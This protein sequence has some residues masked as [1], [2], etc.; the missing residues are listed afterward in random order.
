MNSF[1]VSTIFKHE[2]Q[3]IPEKPV[4]G[5][6]LFA[7]IYLLFI[8]LWISCYLTLIRTLSAFSMRQAIT[9]IFETAAMNTEYKQYTDITTKQYMNDF[10]N[11]VVI[12]RIYDE[13]TKQYMPLNSNYHYINYYN[14]FMGLRI[15]QNRVDLSANSNKNSNDAKSRIRK[16][17]YSGDTTVRYGDLD[18]TEFGTD[19]IQYWKSCGYANAGGFVHFFNSSITLTQ[20]QNKFNTMIIVKA[21]V[22]TSP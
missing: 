18:K 2:T 14:Y 6:F 13:S 22:V 19:E 1:D 11:N 16:I 7:A 20:A 12:N 4:P 17:N 21:F 3:P 15:T 5:S 9:N 8:V 10:I